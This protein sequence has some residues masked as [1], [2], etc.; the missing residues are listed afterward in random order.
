MKYQGPYKIDG[1][2]QN[3]NYIFTM[4]NGK[5]TYHANILKK[6]E[7]REPSPPLQPVVENGCTGFVRHKEYEEIGIIMLEPKRKEY[8]KDVTISE[9][10]T[11]YQNKEARELLQT[12]A[13][14]LSDIPGKTERVEHKI[15][16]T[17]ETP[18]RMK[19]YPLPVHAMDEVD[20]EINFKLESGIISKSTSPYASPITVVMKKDG[21]IR[22]CLDFRR[23]N[24]ITIFDA[25][26]IPTLDELLGKMKGAK[27]FTKYDLTK[28]Y[29][30]IPM[31][32]D[33]KAYTAFQTTQGLIEFNYM[34]FGLSTA[35]CT[36][37][38]AMLDTLGKPPF[39]VSYFDDVLIFSKSWKE[40]LE[41]IEKTL[42]ALREAGF[43]LKPSKTI[44]GC[45][46]IN[47]LGH[48][49]GKGQLKPDENKTEKIRNL[50]VPTTK[51]EVR[52]VLGLL[53]Y[54]RR[55][56]HNFSAIAQLLTELTKKSR[57]NKIVWTPECQ[58]SWDAIEK[59]L[60]SEPILKVPDP[61]K[62]FVVQTD[63]SNKAIA[64]TLLQQHEGTL[65]PCFY[66]SRTLKD[67]ERNYA[68]IELEMLAIIFALDK[69][70]K[71]LLMKPFLIQTDHPPLSFLKEN[72]NC[73]ELRILQ[74]LYR[75][76][77]AAAR[78]DGD[79]RELKPIRRGPRHGCKMSPDL[80]RNNLRNIK[81][82]EGIKINGHNIIN[83]RHAGDTVLIRGSE[84]E[85]QLILDTLA[86]ESSERGLELNIKKT[87]CMVVIKG[88]R[89]THK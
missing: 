88:R 69:F 23:L 89:N 17:D 4:R 65:H 14:T 56:V 80:Q 24:K 44:V 77:E 11:P 29:W 1:V 36:F 81:S 6:Y 9:N 47:F 12:F 19:Q 66:A 84:N 85:I 8:P 31:H 30:Q 58:E 39:V 62:P 53:N 34:P 78:M 70:S 72:K 45:E 28:G 75:E 73:K 60:T 3:N 74:N 76:Q 59:C 41:H 40:H 42:S 50:R 5:R 21:A 61:S 22:L 43:T 51:K 71:Y 67:R 16:L 15:R 52:S 10:L 63:A 54:Y 86:E 55:F 46:H 13:D 48:I 7:E 33:S 25:Q 37:Q 26:P 32:E 49:V 2:A 82:N 79:C 27:F 35:A 57:P 64:G 68:I 20:K 87:E 83:L 38:R 18:F